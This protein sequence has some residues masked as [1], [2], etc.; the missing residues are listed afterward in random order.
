MDLLNQLEAAEGRAAMNDDVA[1][2]EDTYYQ[3]I[4]LRRAL[5]ELL[6]RMEAEDDLDGH[7]AELAFEALEATGLEELIRETLGGEAQEPD[8]DDPYNYRPPDEPWIPPAWKQPPPKGEWDDPGTKP[9]K[10]ESPPGV[11]HVYDPAPL[12]RPES[13]PP[14]QGGPIP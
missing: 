3:G 7:G 14:E 13:Q 8:P 5:H 9:A 11:N 1:R 4:I 6:R 10:P 2:P 12:P